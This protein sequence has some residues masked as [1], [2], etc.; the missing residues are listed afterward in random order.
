MEKETKIF[1]W[2]Q[3]L[4]VHHRIESA[5]KRVEF[6]SDKTSH[7]VPKGRWCNVIVLNAHAARK[8][9]TDDSE[10]SFMRH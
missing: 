2:E 7:T 6:V 9:K 8:K 4:F 5:L 10:D 3:V 1:T